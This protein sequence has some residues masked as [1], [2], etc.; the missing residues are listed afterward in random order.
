MAD[1]SA[2]K[3]NRLRWKLATVPFFFLFTAIDIIVN[4]MHVIT[5]PH[6]DPDSRRAPPQFNVY[7]I[8]FCFKMA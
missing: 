1:M 7:V 3:R 2:R 8:C 6:S 5:A 4:A